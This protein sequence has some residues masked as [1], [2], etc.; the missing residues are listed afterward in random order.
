MTQARSQLRLLPLWTIA[1]LLALSSVEAADNAFT[2]RLSDGSVGYGDLL[3]SP[4]SEQMAFHVQ[5]FAQPYLFPLE[6]VRSVRR[7]SGNTTNDG[8]K[9]Q[10]PD[11]FLFTLTGREQLVGK[12]VSWGQDLITVESKSLGRLEIPRSRLQR[13]SNSPNVAL[14][15]KSVFEKDDWKDPNDSDL[16]DLTSLNLSTNQPGSRIVSTYESPSLAEIK[17]ELQWKR[18]PQFAIGFGVDPSKKLNQLDARQWGFG[19]Q[20][21]KSPTTGRVQCF[22]SLEVWGNTLVLV[23]E[24]SEKGQFAAIKELSSDSSVELTIFLDLNTGLAAV[25]SQDGKLYQ[26]Q[27]DTKEGKTPNAVQLQNFGSSLSLERLELKNWNGQLPIEYSQGQSVV[28]KADGTTLEGEVE[29]WE[30]A[31]ASWLVRTPSEQL[32]IPA[33]EMKIASFSPSQQTTESSSIVAEVALLDGSKVKGK[34]FASGPSM[35]EFQPSFAPQPRSL[36]IDDIAE[37]LVLNTQAEEKAKETVERVK[38]AAIGLSQIRG[39]FLN[40]SPACPTVLHWKPTTA[41]NSSEFDFKLSGEVRVEKQQRA[42][43]PVA[44]IT[45]EPEP[46]VVVRE[47]NVFEQLFGGAPANRPR[48]DK[49]KEKPK[50]KATVTNESQIRFRSGDI[51]PAVVREV[52]DKG[53]QFEST[54]TATTFAPNKAVD[55]VFFRPARSSKLSDDERKR[56]LTIPRAQKNDPP[57]HLVISIAGDYLR[58]HLVSVSPEKTTIEVR[59]DIMEFP[60]EELSEIIW[61][62]D[63]N[64][65]TQESNEQAAD[66]QESNSNLDETILA[67]HVVNA[68]DQGLTLLPVSVQGGVLAGKSSII[69]DVTIK[70]DEISQ[71]FFGPETGL[72]ARQ[73]R[74]VTYELELAQMPREQSDAEGGISSPVAHPLVGKPAPEWS[75][76]NLSGKQVRLNDQRGKITVIDFWASWCGPCMQAMPQVE[77]LVEEFS[78]QQVQLVAVNIQETKSRIEIALQRLEVHCEVLLDSD[79]ET[80]AAYKAN[81]IPQTVIVDKQGVVADVIIGGGPNA[82]TQIRQSLVRLLLEESDP[83]RAN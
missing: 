7:L 46:A 40:D 67:V 29:G 30:E 27:V 24:A 28:I 34:L 57:T 37:L 41:I 20:K 48:V 6:R 12:I 81:A 56:L 2:V 54:R 83:T 74:N 11:S 76:K 39:E 73:R 8:S 38:L 44:P 75:L 22:M 59:G 62:Y 21:G 15:I 80:A 71:L 82:L 68:D 66:S 14:P 31:S 77:Q 16:W 69:G 4:E 60:T 19:E 78:D 49:K 9:K 64:W 72:K 36:R 26:L 53:V 61:L 42:K 17:L 50:P 35:L 33:T 25:Q 65:K 1:V 45:S 52:T 63:R 13:I 3:A 79:G 5:G 23:R 55:Q 47:F 58:G 10:A 32:R 43:P 70:L 18:K 51:A